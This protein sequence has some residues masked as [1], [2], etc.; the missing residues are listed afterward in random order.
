MAW[1]K[2]EEDKHN[3]ACRVISFSQFYFIYPLFKRGSPIEI[4]YLL[5]PG[6]KVAPE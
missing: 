2:E 5:C 3:N 4:Q 1:K 6:V